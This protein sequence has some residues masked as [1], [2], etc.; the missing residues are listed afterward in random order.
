MNHDK[1]ICKIEIIMIVSRFS[2]ASENSIE[3][4]VVQLVFCLDVFILTVVACKI[5]QF[6]TY[7]WL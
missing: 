2:G 7:I 5:C 4:V 3:C 1:L 6:I